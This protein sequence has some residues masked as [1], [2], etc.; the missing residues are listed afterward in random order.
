MRFQPSLYSGQRCPDICDLLLIFCSRCQERFPQFFRL[1]VA[2]AE[3]DEPFD[4][5]HCLLFFPW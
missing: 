5:L 1:I 3:G 2:W 4:D